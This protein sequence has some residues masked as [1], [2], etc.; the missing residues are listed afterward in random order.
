VS[1]VF[2][3]LFFQKEN[4][5]SLKKRKIFQLTMKNNFHRINAIISQLLEKIIKTAT[6]KPI[7]IRKIIKGLADNGVLYE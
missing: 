2:L 4:F 5:A 6:F 3:F 7:K 1:L